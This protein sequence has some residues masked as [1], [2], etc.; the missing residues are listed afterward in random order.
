[1]VIGR[2]RSTSASSL[3]RPG[4]YYTC[5]FASQAENLLAFVRAFKALPQ[6]EHVDYRIA[7][8]D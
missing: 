8:P 5:L 7:P 2:P 4:A 1:M 6:G 3:P